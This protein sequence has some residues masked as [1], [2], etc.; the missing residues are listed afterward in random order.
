MCVHH[1]ET[2]AGA[3]AGV[4]LFNNPGGRRPPGAYF[5]PRYFAQTFELPLVM[6][7]VVVLFAS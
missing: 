5:A 4:S 1:K 7:F 3:L 6:T 2:P